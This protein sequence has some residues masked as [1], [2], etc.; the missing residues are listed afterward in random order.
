M[1]VYSR[2][3]MILRRLIHILRIYCKLQLLHLRIY[4]E[5]RA[6][7][8]IGIIG[9]GLTQGAGLVFI[10][11][12]F[13]RVPQV[14]GWNNWQIV[15]LYSLVL[16][17]NGLTDLL[18]S[19]Q[20]QLRSLVNKGELDRILIRPI[21][22]ALQVISRESGI[23]GVGSV[24]LGTIVLSSTVHT[25]HLSWSVLQYGFLFLTLI[26]SV[27]LM[28]SVNFATNC[29][30][31]WDASANSAFP[32]MVQYNMEFAKYP[33]NLYSR[34]VQTFITWILPYAFVS[35]YPSLILLGQTG[36]LV[37]LG[38]CSPLAGPAMALVAS[39][40][41]RRGLSRYQGTGY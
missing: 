22:P 14:G 35:Y 19:G 31:F 23:Q 30:A 41:W 2:K 37:W 1:V 12:L 8:W 29:I 18:Y 20:W 15:L 33:I 21:S 27:L 26:S 7:F 11:A 34:L 6:D 9:M 3:I 39:I 36:G 38:Y 10:W 25:L 28:G 40:I 13:K 16:I 24:L 5:Y 32:F 4:L 17:P